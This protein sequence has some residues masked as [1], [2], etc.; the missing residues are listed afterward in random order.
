[1]KSRDPRIDTYIA[2][3]APFARPILT[4]LRTLMHTAY[5][6]VV[7]DLKWGAPA[8]LHGTKLLCI[9]ASFKA[10][11]T[12]VFW[13]RAMGAELGAYAKSGEAMGQLGRLASLAD[14]PPDKTL[15]RCIRRAVEL[16]DA[17]VP[18]RTP[19][20]R[21]PVSEKAIPADLAEALA[22]NRAAAATF[23]KFSPSHRKEYIEWIIEAK[24]PETRQKRLATTLAWLAEGKARNWKYER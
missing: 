20:T 6:A 9:M 2:R 10:H 18:S 22:G 13:N 14:L 15:L 1:M 3:S 12:F 16:S 21:K 11:C 17:K 8:F 5:P 23:A 7:E 19:R 4:R 24:R